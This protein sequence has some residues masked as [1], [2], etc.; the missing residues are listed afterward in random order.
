M[1][2][3]FLAV[4]IAALVAAAAA[5]SA[6]AA[7]CDPP[8]T[9]EIACENSKPGSPASE[10]DIQGAGDPDIQGFATDIS[11][12]QGQTI[13]FKVDTLA[14][15]YRLDI[16]RMGWYGG[17]GARRVATV[18]PTAPIFGTQRSCLFDDGTGLV[19]CGNWAQSASW[20]VPADAVSGIYFAKLVREDLSTGASHIVFVVRDD[21]GGSELLFQTSDTTW[22]AYNRYGGNSLYTGSPA[23]RAYKV[24]YNRPFTTREYAP[25]D[26]VFN[27]EYPMVR[28]LER[29]GY[30]L[31]YTTGIDSHRRAAEILEHETFLSVG[32]DEYWSGGQRTNVEN[33]RSAGVNLAFISG[34]EVFWKTRWEPSIAA[35]AAAHRTLV[36]Y[37]ETHANAKI[38][39]APGVWTGTWRDPRF[40][41]PADGGRP[42]NA[43]TGQ[44]FTINDGAT[45]A[46][47]VPSADG[48]LR[49]W[50]HTNI[51]AL[52]S[53]QEATLA[54]QT[55]GYEW[56]EDLDNGHRPPGSIRMSTTTVQGAPAL[57]DYGSTF[58]SR[59]ATHHLTLYKHQSGALVFGAGTVQWPWGLDAEHDR[60]T[61]NAVDARMQQATVNLLADMGAQ[62][63]TIQSGL[64]QATQTTDT[65][66][67]FSAI[68]SPSDGA[69]AQ[70]GT[71]I[72]ITGHASDGEAGGRVAGVEVSTDNGQTWHPAEGREDWS[73]TWTPAQTGTVTLRSRAI[74]DS[75][76]VQSPA[77]SATITVAEEVPNTCPCSVFDP[78]AT[79][80][81]TNLNDGSPL[82]V[83]M[84]FRSDE[85][86]Y[87][88]ALRFYKGAGNGGT[89]TGHL[90]SATGQLLAEARF[91][92]ETASGWQQVKLL[93]PVPVA[94]N[95]TYVVSY[96]SSE[97]GYAADD[98]FF[99]N[100]VDNPPLH[101]LADG[102][103]GGNGVYRYGSSG[104]PTSSWN[105][106]NYWADVVF[107]RQIA[108]DSTAPRVTSVTPAA[109]TQDAN[110]GGA[111]SA[112]FD[113]ALDPS[114]VTAGNFTLRTAGGASVSANVS[115]DVGTTTAT[116]TPSQRLESGASYTA[117]V[118]GGAGGIA[119]RAGNRLAQDR[120]WTFTTAVPPTCPCSLFGPSAVPAQPDA[121]EGIPVEVG[122]KFRADEDGYVS[123]LR[124]YKGITNTGTHVG[125]LWTR[126]GRK[127]AE[128][129]FAPE[130][131]SGWQQVQFDRPVAVSANVTYVASYH[132]PTGAYALDEPYFGS[133]LDNPPLHAPAN[134]VDGANGVYRYGSSSFPT[135]SFAAS[136]YWVDVVFVRDAGPDTTP[137]EA[138]PVRP[139]DGA[140]EVSTQ[141]NV[142]VS[143]NEPL[144]A[145]TLSASTFTLRGPGGTQ[146]QADVA[147]DPGE[148][149]ATLTPQQALGFATTYTATV[150]GGPTGV[151]DR[152]GNR[153]QQDRTWS[154]ETEPPPPPPPTQGP[155][156]PILVVGSAAN[157]FGTYTAEILRAEGLNQFAIAD[158]SAV[159]AQTLSNH[160]VVVL[161]QAA[162]SDAQV[163]MFTNWVQNGGNLIAMR[164]DKKLAG[165]LGLADAGGT[166]SKAYMRVDTGSSPGAGIAG[167][168]M[169][170]HGAADRYTLGGARQVAGLYSDASTPTANPAVTVRSVGSSGGQAAAFTYDLSRSVVYTR[171]GNPSWSGQERDAFSP[172]RSDDLFF[173]A[174]A[175]DPADDWVD[176]DRV[177]VPQADEQ[178]RLLANLITD[179][180]LDRAPLPRFW[181]LPRGEKAAVVMT[182]DDHSHNG[183]SGQFDRFKAASPPG[184]SVADW[185]CIRATSYV[186]PDTPISDAA[187]SQYEAEGFELALHVNTGCANF[188]RTALD[189]FF[190]G[191]L[192]SFGEAWPS[193]AP[194][195]TNRTH[196]IAYSDWASTPKSSLAHG[197]RL[198]T[199]YYYWPASW[200]LDR[201]GLFTGSGIPMRF[202][203]AD[204]SM[205]DVYQATTQLTDESGQNLPLHINALINNALGPQGYYGVFTTN[206]HTDSPV[207]QGADAIVAEA[208]ARGVPVISARQLLAWL[209]GRNNSAFRNMSFAQNQLRFTIDRAAGARGLEAMVP[210]V[211]AGGPLGSLTRNGTGV[212]ASERVVKGVRYLVFDAVP[213]NYVASYEADDDPPVIAGTTATARV[214]G[215]ATIAWTTNE[216]ASSRV[217]YGTG[218]TAL[219]EDVSDPARVTDHSLELTGLSP[220]TTYHYRVSSTDKADNTAS[221][222][223]AAAPPAT[224]GTPA[225]LTDSTTADFAAGT[226]SGTYAGASG[227]AQD[228]E[229]QLSP[230]VAEE[231]DGPQIPS[232]W[233]VTPWTSGGAGSIASSALAVDGAR[234]GTTATYPS[235]RSLEF[236]ATLGGAP[237]RHVGF[238]VDLNNAP[239][240][241]FSTGGGS[242]ATGLYARTAGSAT[243][244]T[245]VPGVAATTP[246]RYRIDW[247]P[248]SVQ[249][250]VNRTQ[251]ASHTSTISAPMRPLE[252]DF[253]LGGGDVRVHWLRMSPYVSTGTFTSRVLDA[254]RR[255]DWGALES[256]RAAPTGTQIDFEA[257]SG[258]TGTPDGTWSAW[259]PVGA[260]G[261]VASPNARFVQYRATLST[262]STRETPTIEQ[263]R[264]AYVPAP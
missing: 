75:G 79:P 126:G 11:V 19:D 44:L 145:S 211:G 9:S 121:G 158:L 136:N 238:G 260:A 186:F 221:F 4:A 155:G 250:F 40:S 109:G 86:G 56:D 55:L 246:Q 64:T 133:G 138:T 103:D 21:D 110:P 215:T 7:P 1:R 179:M 165:L 131:A 247:T 129:T 118:K 106:S 195:R 114:T 26:W 27:A 36:S 229:V 208:Q 198:D 43:L 190:E 163:A 134:G 95:A 12:D 228:G 73:Y 223:A 162:L 239:W 253:S 15:D 200:V 225:S 199:N 13:G 81:N 10:W 214:D 192:G 233:S 168:T 156:G 83:G 216:A 160:Q 219:T 194:P 217:Q 123:G 100:P 170:F 218:P 47:R 50:R 209:D 237:F 120:V 205:I 92:N 175:G 182:G 25:E 115:Y 8:V 89:H 255:A 245:A 85:D 152:A 206:M 101:G 84:K 230:T 46:I 113:E 183:T 167:Q 151:A 159:T 257:R 63:A 2:R 166:L 80:R 104:F 74:D 254:G 90:W 137:P 252:S 187:G 148:G 24:S 17:D 212:S 78:A 20:T 107:E 242:L 189:A 236:F 231:F 58:G 258:D 191:Q 153:M 264:V 57:E 72:Q 52:S 60:G 71:S 33:A 234:A 42:E 141:A 49:L 262:A 232:A 51:A 226:Q 185:E 96:H 149:T 87:V 37:K 34:N 142:T 177:S 48:K 38:D 3:L 117:T 53:G 91:T 127:L 171:Q 139:V 54:P 147:Y 67:P 222:P 188:T 243:A 70:V 28:W 94:R 5:P 244:N 140:Q 22:Q 227:V 128:A 102:V 45:T 169:Q 173:G 174:A 154:F 39:P 235:G 41:P 68:A 202:A 14:T 248:T 116:L 180:N 240:G 144:N 256:T 249:Y 88:T 241:I 172:I 251:V 59:T 112:T 207:H 66:A 146:V 132:S 35:G 32:H 93:S 130:T 105:S 259:Q 193:V 150:K 201:P 135:Q 97:G 181:Y 62:P 161:G 69:T 76:N 210:A 184:C 122:V 196:C 157:P 82:E 124:F 203:D 29:N 176:F 65:S 263:V 261:T 98:P 224:F 6:S 197:I 213:G 16:Y 178:Q 18:Q 108:P 77:A 125:H 204:G 164:P 111:V 143:F 99:A 31:S 30:D 220:G 61:A 119:D 23:G